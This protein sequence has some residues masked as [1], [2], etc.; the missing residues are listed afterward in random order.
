M[1]RTRPL[2]L[3]CAVSAARRARAAAVSSR[4]ARRRTE[5]KMQRHWT[6]LRRMLREWSITSDA[7]AGVSQADWI[8]ALER[9]LRALF[10]GQ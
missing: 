2:A 4:E 1:A 8:A 9:A 10:S 6:V 7:P 5:E 3:A